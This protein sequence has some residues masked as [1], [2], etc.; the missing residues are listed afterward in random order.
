MPR[1][2]KQTRCKNCQFFDE[3]DCGCRV[4]A[5]TL[6]VY[7]KEI[8]CHF[9]KPDQNQWCGQFKA[10]EDPVCGDPACACAPQ[11]TG[12]KLETEDPD[13]V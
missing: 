7:K 10:T 4:N 2:T 3:N 1:P 11:D 9:P 13:N 5:P 8:C 6:F 12:D